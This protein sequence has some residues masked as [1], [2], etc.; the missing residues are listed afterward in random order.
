[1]RSVD[2]SNR[3]DVTLVLDREGVI[4][5]ARFSHVVP[6]ADQTGWTGRRWTDTVIDGAATTVRR[7]LADAESLGVAAY[8]EVRQTFPSGAEL[9]VEY[10]AVA[11]GGDAGV[12]VIGKSL[13][14]TARLQARLTAAQQSLERDYHRLSQLETLHQRLLQGCGEA[15]LIVDQADCTIIEANPVALD[16][17]GPAHGPSGR[18]NDA[19]FLAS[20]ET[21]E[22]RAVQALLQRVLEHGSAATIVVHPGADRRPRRLR[23]ANVTVARGP[24]YLVQLAPVDGACAAS[25]DAALPHALE[26]L[27]DNAPDAFVVTDPEGIVLYANRAFLDLVQACASGAVIGK[28]IAGWLARPGADAAVLLANAIEHGAV[29]L[30]ATTLAGDLGAQ[31][32][33][34]VSAV[35][36]DPGAPR[37]C[38]LFLRDVSRRLPGLVQEGELGLVLASLTRQLGSKRLR[39]LVQDGVGVLERHY[40]EAALELTRGNRTAAAEL[41]GLSRQSLYTKLA[42]Y[43]LE[44]VATGR[45]PA[46]DT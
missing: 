24:A 41:L 18:T 14:T 20:F 30:F 46:S 22:R 3:P 45:P 32:E 26:R 21:D 31:R 1:M 11:R 29:R 25:R 16:L 19:D 17:L 15:V 12:V 35:V 10:T 40:I 28:R 42:R 33:V 34:E 43:E 5:E 27:V 2:D 6:A 13:Q 23:A 37:H 36:D 9:P 39:D 38:A 4:R 44:Q 7:L 8:H